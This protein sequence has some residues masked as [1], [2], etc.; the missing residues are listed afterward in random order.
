MFGLG[1]Y[2]DDLSTSAKL[3]N[4]K[5]PPPPADDNSFK[6][7]DIFK[8]VDEVPFKADKSGQPYGV[9]A[10]ESESKLK[11]EYSVT[12][13]IRWDTPPVNP[14]YN[15]WRLSLYKEEDN[16][17]TKRLGDRDHTLFKHLDYYHFTSY[18]YSNLNGAGEANVW[19]NI[20]HG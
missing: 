16:L 13:W 14:W 3:L 2:I 8:G 1:A 10:I 6:T 19:Q 20:P 7:V 17:N 11:S 9:Q 4:S 5:I 15:V 18:S 12:G